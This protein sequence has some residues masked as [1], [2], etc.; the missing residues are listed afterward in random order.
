MQVFEAQ[1]LFSLKMIFDLDDELESVAKGQP[2]NAQLVNKFTSKISEIPMPRSSLS[3]VEKNSTAF[4]YW[5]DKHLEAERKVNLRAAI[6]KAGADKQKLALVRGLLAPYLRD[7]L[8]GFNYIHYTPPGEQI[9]QTNPL[10]VRSHDF[11]GL[12]AI[13]QMW[14]PTEIYGSGWPANAG[15]R[16]VGSMVSLPYALAEAEQNFLIPTREQALIWGDLVPQMLIS[17]KIPRWWNTTPAQLSW[18]DV[19]MNRG[20]SLIAESVAD[21]EPPREVVDLLSPH[22]PP[23]RVHA[24]EQ[25]IAAGGPPRRCRRSPRPRFICWPRDWWTT[26]PPMLPCSAK[27]RKPPLH[28]CSGS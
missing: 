28:P 17:A 9:L 1:K 23:V 5:S 11:I 13:S 14:R 8:V 7:T 27:N 15:G 26:T 19:H 3:T 25:A 16:L 12:Q 6:E 20:E 21:T 24:A 22:A 10:F 2:L 18:I 4:G